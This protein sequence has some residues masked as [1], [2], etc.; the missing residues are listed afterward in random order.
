MTHQ[1]KVMLR[2]PLLSEVLKE[3]VYDGDNEDGLPNVR[4]VVVWGR[5]GGGPR[6]KPEVFRLCGLLDPRPN[7]VPDKIRDQLY[8]LLWNSTGGCKEGSLAKCRA[9]FDKRFI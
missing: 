1:Q 7:Y 5:A 2:L 6:G 9:T 8:Q 3:H 4:F